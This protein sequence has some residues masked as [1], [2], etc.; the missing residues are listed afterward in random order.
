MLLDYNFQPMIVAMRLREGLQT[1]EQDFLL[2]ESMLVSTGS[3]SR[4][5]PNERANKREES[6][7]S[8]DSDLLLSEREKV[9][10]PSQYKV[11]LINDDYTPMDFV[12]DILEDL[13]NLPRLEAI[14]IMLQVHNKGIGVCGLFPYEI[15]E[16]KARQVMILARKN[17]H[18]LQC[19][20]EKEKA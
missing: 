18:P 1:S 11:L 15:A 19:V 8:P 17:E 10:P 5:Q 9:E 14:D 6:N 16:T 12:I 2:Q 20:V 13:F 4:R 7:A 3:P